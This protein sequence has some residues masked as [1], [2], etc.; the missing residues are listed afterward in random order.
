LV[1]GGNG[2]GWGDADGHG[3]AMAG[4]IAAHGHGASLGDGAL[5]VAPGAKIL[6]VRL[7]TPSH[8]PEK[9]SVG[10]AIRW[11]LAHGA[12][13][14][15]VSQDSGG[16]DFEA[17]KEAVAAGAIIVASAGN[18]TDNTYAPAPA[19]YDGY[20]LAV[21]GT[22]RDGNHSSFSVKSASVDL[23]APGDHITSTGRNHGYVTSTGT[24]DSTAIVSGALAL[25]WSKYP[26]LTA[27]QVIHRLVATAIDRGAPGKDEETGYGLIDIVA[28]LTADVSD[29]SPSAATASPAA[30]PSSSSS[31]EPDG[32][33]SNSALLIGGVIAAV[34]ILVLIVIAV[35]RRRR[36]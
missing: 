10:P 2:N 36:G 24:S 13:I 28:A 27:D 8:P 18:T 16:G 31:S 35:T 29:V 9:G 20:A 5:G 19:R 6:P 25:I 1:P 7:S 15:S 17:V 4:L 34:L 22:G 32:G 30:Q 14:I 26:N 3:T 23:A 21:G 11:A 12:K 33:S